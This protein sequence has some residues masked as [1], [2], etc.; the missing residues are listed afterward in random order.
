MNA[1]LHWTVIA[2]LA[3]GHGIGMC[4]HQHAS[5]AE[6]TACP[7]TPQPWPDVCDLLVRQVRATA[8]IAPPVQLAMFDQPRRERPLRQR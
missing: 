7:W 4:G 2:V 6:A 1:P 5:A 3:T 8:P